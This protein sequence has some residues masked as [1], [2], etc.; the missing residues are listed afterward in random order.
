MNKPISKILLLLFISVY[1]STECNAQL[2]SDFTRFQNFKLEEKRDKPAISEFVKYSR[3]NTNELQFITSA[4][5][6]IYKDFISSQDA[7]TCAFTPSCSVYAVQTIKNKGFIGIFDAC[8]R[9]MRCNPF[10]PELY[11]ADKHLHV[12][13]DPVE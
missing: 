10:S 7:L 8:D 12:F 9:L 2:K 5:F 4:L 13:I 3:N 11:K 6:L 1:I